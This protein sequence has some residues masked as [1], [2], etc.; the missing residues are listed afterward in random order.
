MPPRRLLT[1]LRHAA[2]HELT[3]LILPAAL[4]ALLWI[5]SH[6]WY[7]WYCSL[8]PGTRIAPPAPMTPAIKVRILAGA[9]HFTDD[10]AMQAAFV[11]GKIEPPGTMSLGTA[12]NIN[13]GTAA[14]G[15]SIHWSPYGFNAT[16]WKPEYFPGN[17][18]LPL[19]IPFTLFL[20]PPLTFY[21]L[22]RPRLPGLCP[23]C[24][25]SR[26]G[27]PITTPCPECGKL[28]S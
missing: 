19:Y 27:I 15:L 16:R 13:D 11:A 3:L 8:P 7:I 22:T 6:L 18:N 14:S 1:T 2:R 17:W 21:L 4:T 9:V 10:A 5:A 28:P 23:H 12:Y 25:Y 26:T 24:K 20:L